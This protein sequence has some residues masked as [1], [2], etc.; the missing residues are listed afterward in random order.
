M[1]IDS[2]WPGATSAFPRTTEIDHDASRHAPPSVRL[3][4][5][6]GGEPPRVAVASG[7]ELS[8]CHCP[9]TGSWDISA[10]AMLKAPLATPEEIWTPLTL[11]RTEAEPPCWH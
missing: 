4:R 11:I 6:P 7:Q 2:L 8:S 9:L 1:Q 3:Y 10:D 5:D